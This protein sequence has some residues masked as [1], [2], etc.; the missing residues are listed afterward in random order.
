MALA[1]AQHTEV[2]RYLLLNGQAVP[3][4]L[5]RSKVA[6][7]L[8]IKVGPGGVLVV[9][10][11]G[12]DSREAADFIAENRDWVAEQLERS[13]KLLAA[14]RPVKRADGCIAFRGETMAV[15]V[16]HKEDWRVPNKVVL[17]SVAITI[18]CAPDSKTPPARSLENWLRKQARE[19]IAQHIADIGKRLKRTPNRIYVMGQRTKWGNCS[20][21]GNLS[22]NWKLV[23]APD[24]VLRYIVTHEMV[25]LAVSDHSHKFWLTVQ[26]LC[27]GTERARQWLVVNG[28]RL[29][30]T[31]I[32]AL[33][34]GVPR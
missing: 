29:Q 11:E 2:S 14:R 19:R 30:S 16:V 22:F 28:A 26:S 4:R 18:T 34:T 10:P 6:K 3:W 15:R 27:P 25:H 24:F 9:L 32:E 1:E 33:D 20:S 5:V 17:N 13:R 23:M 12:R 8:R 21:L 31:D 7:K